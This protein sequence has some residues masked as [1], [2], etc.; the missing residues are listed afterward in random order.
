MRVARH[1]DGAPRC[2]EGRAHDPVLAACAGPAHCG[3]QG[4]A[5]SQARS[6][7]HALR[8]AMRRTMRAVSRSRAV[9][10]PHARASAPDCGRALQ[11]P[12]PRRPHPHSLA[13]STGDACYCR[14]LIK[15]RLGAPTGAVQRR[16]RHVRGRGRGCGAV[17][18]VAAGST[19][20]GDAAPGGAGASVARVLRAVGGAARGCMVRVQMVGVGGSGWGSDEGE[21]QPAT[22]FPER[23]A[24]GAPPD[25]RHE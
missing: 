20:S 6:A 3:R 9:G 8:G 13:L 14:N 25:R 10:D 22:V 23:L 4:P 7:P 21:A 19:G 24:V 11:P 2:S 18:L 15:R 5:C 1:D 16:R 12:S 17:Q